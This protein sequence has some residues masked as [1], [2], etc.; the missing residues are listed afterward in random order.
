MGRSPD[1]CCDEQGLKKGPW[2]PEED[3]KLKDYVEKNGQ[4]CWR[5]LP[6]LGGLNRCGKSYRLRWTNYLRPGIKRGKFT[7]EEERLI[8]HLHSL[9]G[10]KWSTIASSLAGRTDNEIKNYWNSHLRKKLLQMGIDPVTHRPQP[11]HLSGCLDISLRLQADVIKLHSLQKLLLQALTRATT[12][13]LNL[14]G[15][16]GSPPW[17][18][19]R[20]LQT[21]SCLLNG[22]QI[23]NGL[24]GNPTQQKPLA[25]DDYCRAGTSHQLTSSSM[26][27]RAS[28]TDSVGG[29]TV[30][31]SIGTLESAPP[32]ADEW[33][34]I[35]LDYLVEDL[36]YCLLE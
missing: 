3:R 15:L 22:S 19:S 28:Q 27:L 11:D 21:E 12:P 6:N 36:G 18:W 25:D 16:L 31:S 26:V 29:S 1:A 4:G 23:L 5:R 30:G 8:V 14:M 2:T 24:D 33:N 32:T 10:N 20:L 9:H 13:S 34:S 35:N 7:G 17:L